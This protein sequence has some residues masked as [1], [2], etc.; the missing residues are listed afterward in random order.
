VIACRI[1]GSPASPAGSVRQFELATCE[2]CGFSFVTNPR[3]DYEAVYD[4]AYYRG[5]GAD[6]LVDYVF[7]LEH[8][9]STIRRYEWQG[10]LER[11]TSLMPSAP[12]GRWLDYGCGTGGL[13]RY[14]RSHGVDATGF[15][16]GWC[17]PRLKEA[18]VPLLS[19]GDQ[20]DVVTAIEVIEHVA[21]PVSILEGVR[22]LL[23][24]SGLLFLTTGNAFPYRGRLASWGYVMPDVHISFFE[25]KTLGL[26]LEKAGFEPATP[27][28]GAGWDKIIRFKVLKTLGFKRTNL[29]E[30]VLPWPVLARVVDRRLGVTAHPVGWAR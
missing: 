23:R 11:V 13:V 16:Q 17:V 28:Y 8:P 12:Q 1:C 20:F 2:S 9:A 21:D 3:E 30:K 18:G 14:L 24:P 7:E 19:E 6:P 5:E 10:I 27:G 25:P 15:E 26:A 4:A 29:A 22:R